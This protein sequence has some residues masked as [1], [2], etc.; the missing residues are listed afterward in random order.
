MSLPAKLPRIAV[1]LAAAALLVSAATSAR[2]ADRLVISKPGVHPTYRLEA[3]PHV[4]LG[5]IEPPGPAHGTGIGVG[6]RGTL[7]VLDN[8]FIPTINNTIGIG[9]GLDWVHYTA[10]PCRDDDSKCRRKFDSLW[11]PLALQWNFWLSEQWSVFGEPGVAMR[12][13]N[14]E[15]RIE[16]IEFWA[17][18]R[19]KFTEGA[20]LTMR[21]GYPTFCVGASFLL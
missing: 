18:G 9:F 19:W 12:F 10:D 3:E 11:V 8:G 1:A 20:T 16:P 2:A 14:S 4:L 17:G 15:M 5:L 21:V 13:G 7:E 6:G